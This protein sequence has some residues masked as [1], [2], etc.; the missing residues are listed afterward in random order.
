MLEGEKKKKRRARARI[1]V[2]PRGAKKVDWKEA[3][4][5]KK[6][7]EISDATRSFLM[8]PGCHFVKDFAIQRYV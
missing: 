1:C 5:G 4:N 3:R 8:Q 2:L 6:R 7:G